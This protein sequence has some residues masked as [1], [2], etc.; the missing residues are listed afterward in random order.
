M[1]RED[2]AQH[3]SPVAERRAFGDNGGGHGVVSTNADAHEHSHAKQ[4]PELV[5]RRAS[6]VV[7]QADDQ[8]DAYHHDDHLFSIDK[9]SAKGI[10]QK[11]KRQLTNDITNVGGGVDGTT[12]QERVGGIL[13]RGLFEA[14]PVF[15]GPYRGDQVDDEEIVGV[16]KESDT[17]G[18]V[19]GSDYDV[20]AYAS[21]PQMAYSL[22]S[23]LVIIRLAPETL[24]DSSYSSCMMIRGWDKQSV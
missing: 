12:K 22:R 18:C 14:A 16:E 15:V 23:P 20:G 5:P 7:G 19:S 21:H 3:A 8:Y 17:N 6:Q 11:T 2:P 1:I 13:D 4:I 9:S 24:C 10:A